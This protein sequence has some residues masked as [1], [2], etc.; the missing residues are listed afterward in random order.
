MQHPIIVEPAYEDTPTRIVDRLRKVPVSDHI[1]DLKVL[2]G[3]QIVRCDKRVC[4]LSSK[5][6]T[7]PLDLQNEYSLASTAQYI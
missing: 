6:F 2:V 4:R 3:N 5:I 1:T 7:L